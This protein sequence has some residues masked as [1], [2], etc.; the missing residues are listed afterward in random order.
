[1]VRHSGNTAGLRLA[2]GLCL[3]YTL[4][5]LVLRAFIRW[6]A[7]A[8]DDGVVLISTILALAFFGCGYASAARGLGRPDAELDLQQQAF[9]DQLNKVILASNLTW[10]VALCVSKVVIVAML[11]RTTRTRSHRR[12]QH[13]VGLL[14]GTQCVISIILLTLKCSPSHTLAWDLQS[15]QEE[16]P[17]KEAR[18]LVITILDILTELLLLLLP[19]QLVWGLKMDCRNRIYVI[20]AFWLR[21]PTLIFS[22]IRYKAT[23]NLTTSSNISPNAALVLI[24]QAVQLSYSVAAATLAALKRFTES[25]NTGFGHGEL[26]RVHGTSESYPLSDQS[27]SRKRSKSSKASSSHRPPYHDITVDSMETEAELPPPRKGSI[28]AHHRTM[29]LR[30]EKLHNTATVSSPAADAIL[31]LSDAGLTNDNSIRQEVHYSV[32]YSSAS[33][34]RPARPR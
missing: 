34:E 27:E 16:C 18:W 21:L 22:I 32:H 4:C 29:R 11:L 25:M 24:W 6:R 15:G 23:H 5:V 20:A 13:G 14:I 9:V 31:E 19:L 3:C 12:V 26:I 10:M 28:A 30:P 2:L 8:V 17:G 33:C 7:Y 1:M